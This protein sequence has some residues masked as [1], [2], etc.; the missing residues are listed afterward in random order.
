LHLVDGTEENVGQAYETVRHEIEAY[1]HGLWK[2]HELVALSKIDA[3]T[4]DVIAELPPD[5]QVEA[6]RLKALMAE[7]G[8]RAKER[9]ANR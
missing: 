1:G 4:D 5:Q 9:K 7:L 8:R 2:K 3:L 6:L